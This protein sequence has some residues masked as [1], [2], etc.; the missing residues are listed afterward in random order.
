[1]GDGDVVEDDAELLGALRQL[2]VNRRGSARPRRTVP[3]PPSAP[4]EDFIF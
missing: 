2:G 3:P 1:M 4:V